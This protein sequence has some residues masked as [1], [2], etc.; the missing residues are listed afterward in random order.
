MESSLTIDSMSMR[1]GGWMRLTTIVCTTAHPYYGLSAISLM[2]VDIWVR[3][4]PA[5]KRRL[6]YD[7]RLRVRCEVEMYFCRIPRYSFRHASKLLISQAHTVPSCVL[8]ATQWRIPTYRRQRHRPFLARRTALSKTTAE[9]P[10]ELTC[11][12]QHRMIFGWLL[13]RD[14]DSL[15]RILVHL[16]RWPRLNLEFRASRN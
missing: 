15:A 1:Q 3:S 4:H 5:I 2:S 6:G 14:V 8:V 16:V 10:L 13:T 7:I 12:V 9:L 11:K